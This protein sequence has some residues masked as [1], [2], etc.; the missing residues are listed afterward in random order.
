M[1]PVVSRLGELAPNRGIGMTCAFSRHGLADDVAG[2]RG[3]RV[4][5]RLQHAVRCVGPPDAERLGQHRVVGVGGDEGIDVRGVGV[6]LARGDESGADANCVGAQPDRGA[7]GV[8]V[9]DPAG[10]D[11]RNVDRRLE[12]PATA[13]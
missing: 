2:R 6:R 7:N 13:R 9:A 3:R 1:S 4:D 11:N 12:P 10:S 5:C 8:D